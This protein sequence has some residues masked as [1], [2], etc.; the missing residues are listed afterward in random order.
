MDFFRQMY[1]EFS[2]TTALPIR[3]YNP[4]MKDTLGD[5]RIFFGRRRGQE[6]GSS[7]AYSCSMSI[8]S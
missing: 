2:Q 4:T 8:D 1:W 7:A 3:L 6:G 5:L